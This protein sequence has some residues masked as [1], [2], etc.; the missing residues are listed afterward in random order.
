MRRKQAFKA[1]KQE[2]VVSGRQREMGFLKSREWSAV[3]INAEKS[4]TTRPKLSTGLSCVMITGH[5]ERV[6]WDHQTAGSQKP[7][8]LE[9]WMRGG[10]TF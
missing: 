6:V 3:S 5:L 4:G 10:S 1:D 2:S 8:C 7:V 9:G